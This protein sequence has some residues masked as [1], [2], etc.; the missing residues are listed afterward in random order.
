MATYASVIESLHHVRNYADTN[1]DFSLRGRDLPPE[2][3]A[4]L[5]DKL[6]S[7]MADLRKHRDIGNFILSEAAISSMNK[8]MVDLEASTNTV[9]WQ[10][11]LELKLIAVD[12]CLK[13]MRDIARLELRVP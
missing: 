12:G 3:E 1:L 6:R 5:V 10:E 11:H 8:L 2:G 4:D 7:A 13:T 9:H